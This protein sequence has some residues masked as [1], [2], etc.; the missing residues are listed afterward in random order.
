[1]RRLVSIP[2]PDTQTLQ[3]YLYPRTYNLQVLTQEPGDKLTCRVLD[4][5]GHLGVSELH[6]PISTKRLHK[7]GLTPSKSLTFW[8]SSQPGSFWI[9]VYKSLFGK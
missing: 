8:L 9:V 2:I 1:M 3:D 6:P 4:G 5:P 7:M